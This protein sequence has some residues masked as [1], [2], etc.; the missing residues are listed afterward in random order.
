MKVQTL[1]DISDVLINPKTSCPEKVT[2][3]GVANR[4]GKVDVMYQ[5]EDLSFWFHESEL[6]EFHG[7]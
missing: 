5:L 1:Y 6:E 4:S 2:G 3:I 7:E